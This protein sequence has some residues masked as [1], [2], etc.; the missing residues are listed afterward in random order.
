MKSGKREP[1]VVVALSGGPDS[2]FLLDRLLR[3]KKKVVLAHVNHSLRGKESDKDAKFVE[4][5]AKRRGLELKSVKVSLGSARAGI[6]EK[7][8]KIRREFLEKTCRESDGILATGHT[9]DDQVETILMRFFEGA[10]IGGLKGIPVDSVNGPLRPIINVWKEEVLDY[11]N[12]NLMPFRLDR[13]N[14]DSG[15]ERNW[16][17][18]EL[19]PILEKRYGKGVKKRVFV[20]GE[21]FRE[22]DDYLS[23]TASGWIR[24]NV[25]GKA[26]APAFKRKPFAEL[27]SLLR[28]RVLQK[29]CFGILENPPNERLLSAMDK[30]IRL[31]KPS[32]RADIGGG[33]K[34]ANRRE[35]VLFTASGKAPPQNTG[36]I[37]IKDAGK[38]TPERARRVAS[39]GNA[40]AFDSEALRLPLSIRPLRHGDRIIPFGGVGEKKLKEIMI[41]RKIA[42]DKRWG[43]PVVCDSEGK[44]L[45]VPGVI[46]SESARVT[47]STRYVKI[48]CYVAHS[49]D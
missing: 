17:R 18:N 48:L 37:L 1:P 43:R 24:K 6:E 31:G 10:G 8:R 39:S 42:A 15:F 19:I 13:S 27:P 47:I 44:I 23:S 2:V 46:R 25:R 49:E 9:A 21:R 41:D 4:E 35:E 36:E 33:W 28:V 14:L 45:W 32:A 22:L 7:A 12:K 26:K 5:L 40:E 11:L 30:L 20:M 34:L 3:Q 38:M 16:I 29:I